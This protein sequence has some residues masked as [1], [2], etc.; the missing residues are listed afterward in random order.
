[1]ANSDLEKYIET[2]RSKNVSDEAIKTE[3]VK[4]GWPED[5]VSAAISPKPSSGIG[6]PPPPLPR[7]GMWVSFQYIILFICLYVFATSV[8]GIW[9]EAVIR[10]LP[11]NLQAQ[12]YDSYM[13]E[14]MNGALKGYIAAIVVTYPIFAALFLLLKRQVIQR[15]LI[16]NIRARKILIYLTLVVTFLVMISHLILTLIEF[17]NGSASSRSFAHL[18]VTFLI[19][20]TIFGY[21]IHEVAEDRKT[22]V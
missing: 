1:M 18:G 11:D 16:R 3:L 4:S 20:G 5:E 2:A 9:H 12:E 22:H 14:A 21:L 13:R 19:A 7:F 8:G 6:L 17:L 15:P 10:L